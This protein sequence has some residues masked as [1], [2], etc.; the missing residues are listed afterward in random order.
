[1]KRFIKMLCLIFFFTCM[2]QSYHI[3]AT[4]LKEKR[5]ETSVRFTI[6]KEAIQSLY[7]HAVHVKVFVKDDKFDKNNA[8]VIAQKGK[9]DVILKDS[10]W[11]SVKDGYEKEFEISEEG[12][13]Y[14]VHLKENAQSIQ[15]IATSKVFTIDTKKPTLKFYINDK[16][17]EDKQVLIANEK[18]IVK[19]FTSEE[20]I[21]EKNSYFI[22]NKQKVVRDWVKKDGGYQAEL[23]LNK[24]DVFNVSARL[25]DKAGNVNDEGPTFSLTMDV[26]KP[27]IDVLYQEKAIRVNQTIRSKES[28][29]FDVVVKEKNL[30][31]KNSYFLINEQKVFPSWTKSD[32]KYQAVLKFEKDDIYKISSH[33]EDNVGNKAEQEVM[34]TCIK[35]MSKPL[36]SFYIEDD[37]IENK[38]TLYKKDK[39]TLSVIVDEKELNEK[40]SYVLIKGKKT[41]VKWINKEGKYYGSIDF[42]KD[43]LYDISCH[44][45]DKTQNIFDEAYS[46]TLVLDSYKPTI[47]FYHNGKPIDNKQQLFSSKD[48]VTLHLIIKEENFNAQSSYLLV[49]NRKVIPTWYEKEGSYQ[50]DLTLQNEDIY[51]LAYHLEDK[52][53]NVEDKEA[54]FTFNIDHTKPLVSLTFNNESITS[55]IA[56]FYKQEL[57]INFETSDQLLN[58]DASYVL[59]NDKKV[60]LNFDK[61]TNSYI[62][63]ED[64]SD[65]EYRLSYHIE[66]KAGFISEQNFSR[67]FF[68]D[69]KAP[70]LSVVGKSDVITNTS[71]AYQIHLKDQHLEMNNT[72]FYTM[73]DGVKNLTSLNWK[74]VDDDYY[75]TILFD[76]EGSYQFFGEV[77]DKANNRKQSNTYQFIIDKRNPS[78]QL[79]LNHVL[80]KR[81]PSYISNSDVYIKTHI[82]DMHLEN[83]TIEWYK[84]EKPLD[85]KPNSVSGEYLLKSEK[86][87]ND[88]YE[89][90]VEAK[91]KAGNMTEKKISIKIHTKIAPVS[92][93]NDVFHGIAYSGNWKPKVKGEGKDYYVL[94][95]SL[96]RN[97]KKMKYNWGD[98]ITEDGYY[99]LDI[100][101]RD[102]ALNT[103]KM[104]ST[105]YFIIDKTAPL[106]KL[107]SQGV[108]L[109]SNMKLGDQLQLEIEQYDTTK[110]K[111]ER[112]TSIK[113][114]DEQ[115]PTLDEINKKGIF[116]YKPNQTGAYTL[117]AQAIDEAGNQSNKEWHFTVEKTIKHERK[118]ADD[119]LQ[120]LMKRD[121][122]SKRLWILFT[123]VILLSI[124][125][126]IVYEYRKKKNSN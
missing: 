41:V 9:D 74:Q 13:D 5:V 49:N 66:D 10:T 91:D 34:F 89:L 95:S 105:F 119:P 17:I 59:L 102:D 80:M 32:D 99:A 101:V 16:L 11:Q 121:A 45:E 88:D 123:A 78:I 47:S 77:V 7:N 87:T 116:T 69:T 103:A 106:V 23:I 14:C 24:D 85:I 73:K 122:S 76:A 1:M 27:V 18:T 21:L 109:E 43:D 56:N 62:F 75:A 8:I 57:H 82:D 79:E 37:K 118:K 2:Y 98:N 30:N 4:S 113:V 31:E 6:D 107:T 93:E 12:I 114:N 54:L 38:Q 117:V 28:M 25:E 100:T 96:Y 72:S 50:S 63:T 35:D 46:F 97:Q 39:V 44:I 108:A 67:P 86:N 125:I 90:R 112:F 26:H 19:A 115:I 55:E 51:K 124:V 104:K 53:G 92:I 94:S 111:N 61:K 33:I 120:I 81:S 22:V 71:V 70:E 48:S 52:A 20:N 65:G 68:I 42:D 36:V 15:S 126:Y 3:E 64:L 60:K 58:M 40:A 84:N 29:Q 110:R 83:K